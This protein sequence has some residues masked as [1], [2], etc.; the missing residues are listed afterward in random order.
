MATR[1]VAAFVLK[2]A[3]GSFPVQHASPT[4]NR[5]AS[6][7]GAT[8]EDAVGGA[9]SLLAFYKA[10]AG[11]T[12]NQNIADA[13]VVMTDF[14]GMGAPDIKSHVTS[15]GNHKFVT[16]VPPGGFDASVDMTNHW[17]S[18]FMAV[19]TA[20]S[21]KYRCGGIIFKAHTFG[22]TG[23][24]MALI[25]INGTYASPYDAA[26]G[27][28]YASLMVSN[29]DYNAPDGNTP[30]PSAMPSLTGSSSGGEGFF[31]DGLNAY[32]GWVHMQW[33][34][35]GSGAATVRTYCSLIGSAWSGIGD[36]PNAYVDSNNPCLS[37]GI[38]DA[39]Q[40]G[41]AGSSVGNAV[42]RVGCIYLGDDASISTSALQD[43]HA[44][45]A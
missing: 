16:D 40:V 6:A 29:Y 15:T 1:N 42:L 24:E 12:N 25:N 13:E 39:F 17:Q 10:K 27:N 38:S 34:T 8:V 19:A 14:S 18:E 4:R 23:D 36:P 37:A 5:A 33:R 44:L 45:F 32:T 22:S 43:I 11:V 9:M 7:L 28:R 3:G 31:A 2:K 21:S 35:V 20:L 26:N 41:H 30:L